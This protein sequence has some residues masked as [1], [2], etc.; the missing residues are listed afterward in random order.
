MYRHFYMTYVHI[1]RGRNSTLCT[2]L[3]GEN[4]RGDAYTKGE[5]TSFMRNLVLSCFTLCLFSRYFMV[6]GVTFNIYGLLLSSHCVCVLDMHLSL[7]H[8]ASLVACLDDHLHCYMIIVVI[9]NDCLVYD[10]V[11]HMFH[12]MF[13]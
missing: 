10:Q 7:C 13:T 11:T 2:F 1:L 12:I 3:G 6:R 9:S 4:H 5:K 8:C